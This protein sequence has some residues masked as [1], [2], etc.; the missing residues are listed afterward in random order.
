MM[1]LTVL[2]ALLL[3]AGPAVA[4]AKGPQCPYDGVRPPVEEILSIRPKLCKADLSGANLVRADLSGANL[5]RA[6]L[7][8]AKLI[9]KNLEE[10][11]LSG[12][13]LHGAYLT[14]A[15]LRGANLSEA[16]LVG[17]NLSGAD[18]DGANLTR[19]DLTEA[20][21]SAAH[22]EE[23]NLT[24]ANLSGA[25]LHGASF[26]GADLKRANFTGANLTGANL[27]SVKFE[28]DPQSLNSV[29]GIESARGLD[30][31]L[32]EISPTALVVL[33]E[34]F[35]KAG[36]R[37]QEREVTYAKLQSQQDKKWSSKSAP[38]ASRGRFFLSRL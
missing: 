13:S 20:D 35:A 33:R 17:A 18:L 36:L 16:V 31:L 28:P 14:Q 8:G 27:A 26:I 11:N 6:D 19:P 5:S 12:A 24:L 10:A 38:A 1:I 21:L 2:H 3:L 34:R 4:S 22:L 32:F 9:G 25:S 15:H 23:A 7:K 30:R 29:V 37:D